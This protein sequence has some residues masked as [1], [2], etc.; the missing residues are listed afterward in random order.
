M[1]RAALLSVI[2]VMGTL[3]GV[4]VPS[5]AIWAMYV[6]PVDSYAYAWLGETQ[7]YDTGLGWDIEIT[8]D[9]PEPYN[10]EILEVH[11]A[12][13]MAARYESRMSVLNNVYN[14]LL[15]DSAGV[16][17]EFL[18]HFSIE[19]N[20]PDFPTDL[21]V[22]IT[23]GL[24][25][26][27]QTDNIYGEESNVEVDLATLLSEDKWGLKNWYNSYSL[28]CTLLQLSTMDAN[29]ATRSYTFHGS[30]TV[31]TVKAVYVS[32]FMYMQDLKGGQEVVN[33]SGLAYVDPV[34][35]IDPDGMIYYQGKYVPAASMYSVKFSTVNMAPLLEL[36]LQ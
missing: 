16:S 30:V 34:I 13:G 11:T 29:P 8:N 17:C 25:G 10:P 18:Y 14:L 19:P 9:E 31:N 27:V 36:L 35:N 23:I 21:L 33:A 1:K 7:D 6:P 28:D 15:G 24:Q 22:P 12:I 32:A 4:M 2:L 3:W 26:K 20:D 5:P